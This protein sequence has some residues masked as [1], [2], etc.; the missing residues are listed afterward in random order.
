MLTIQSPSPTPD[1]EQ[2]IKGLE[3]K[4]LALTGEMAKRGR[5][6]NEAQKGVETSHQARAASELTIHSCSGVLGVG[7]DRSAV[8]MFEHFGL[9]AV[10]SFAFD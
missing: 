9:S 10:C 2:W 6:D 1:L 5:K 3:E 7:C 4:I 8:D